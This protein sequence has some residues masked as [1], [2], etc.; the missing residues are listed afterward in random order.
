MFGV[1]AIPTCGPPACWIFEGGSSW[2]KAEAFT[3]AGQLPEPAPGFLADD[4]MT[5][6][7]MLVKW[8]LERAL[9]FGLT[10]PPRETRNEK[11]RSQD[12]TKTKKRQQTTTKKK[13]RNQDSYFHLRECPPP[14]NIPNATPAPAPLLGTR[15]NLGDTSGRGGGPSGR[16]SKTR[17][18][19]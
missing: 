11:P 6:Y 16:F 10:S 1:P 4:G 9:I 12:T 13:P 3:M 19:C 14:L 15:G 7:S 18:R 5:E 8:C 17:G 2:L